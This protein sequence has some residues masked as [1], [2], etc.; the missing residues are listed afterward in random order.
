M[1][2]NDPVGSIT[3]KLGDSLSVAKCTQ[4]FGMDRAPHRKQHRTSHQLA[5]LVEHQRVGK[6][7]A[8]L[9]DGLNSTEFW[10]SNRNGTV[11]VSGCVASFAA[12][13]FHSLS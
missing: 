13:V 12:K 11:I 9:A 10:P 5:D 3:Q 1:V 8:D 4:F 6:R 7:Q 2:L